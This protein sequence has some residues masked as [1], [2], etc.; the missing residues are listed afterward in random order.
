MLSINDLPNDI[1]IKI[2]SLLHQFDLASLG[3]TCKTLS[4]VSTKSLYTNVYITV[5]D[6]PISKCV[7]EDRASKTTEFLNWSVINCKNGPISKL[8][9]FE[10]SLLK[11]FHLVQLVRKIICDDIGFML[12]KLKFWCKKYFGETCNLSEVYFGNIPLAHFKLV[13]DDILAMYRTPKIIHGLQF[14]QVNSSEDLM[15][16]ISG[17]DVDTTSISGVSFILTDIRKLDYK[18]TDRAKAVRLFLKLSK[19]HILSTHNLGLSFLRSLKEN[20]GVGIFNVSELRLNHVHGQESTSGRFDFNQLYDLEKERELDFGILVQLFALESLQTLELR[21]GCNHLFCPRTIQDLHFDDLADPGCGCLAAFF[22]QFHNH[23]GSFRSLARISITRLGQSIVANPYNYYNFKQQLLE[24][25]Q[26]TFPKLHSLVVD[27]NSALY[28]YFN[29]TD[30]T[31]FNSMVSLFVQQNDLFAKAMAPI[32]HVCL[33]DYFQSFHLW[34][35]A[36]SNICC[37]CPQ[38]LT[39]KARLDDFIGTNRRIQFY[40]NPTTTKSPDEYYFDVLSKILSLCTPSYSLE[41]IPQ[42]PIMHQASLNTDSLHDAFNHNN[43]CELV[44]VKSNNINIPCNCKGNELDIFKAYLIHQL[45]TTS[46][47]KNSSVILNGIVMVAPHL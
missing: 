18:F 17:I 11:N 20:L 23:K 13:Y 9:Q 37:A 15:D 12:F 1:L 32:S 39:T 8:K 27:T 42:Y 3:Q 31:M 29:Y 35:K 7:E 47:L 19:L 28:P 45:I 26:G 14:L 16:I 5:K 2:T 34:N 6:Y 10:S 24:L 36:K 46:R 25:F 41:R 40:L 4:S 22:R 38:C 44:N 30:D 43:H 33:P 21:I